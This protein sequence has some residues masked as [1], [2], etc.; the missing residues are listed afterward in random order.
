V[1]GVVGELDR[2]AAGGVHDVEVPR[3]GA[4]GC[5]GDARVVGG[6][7]G[8]DVVGGVGGQLGDAARSDALDVD[9]GGAPVL[10]AGEDDAIALMGDVRIEVGALDAV[11]DLHEVLRPVVGAAAGG[12][13]AHRAVDAQL[14]E[15][16]AGGA[17]VDGGDARACEGGVVGLGGE[18]IKEVLVRGGLL[19]VTRIGEARQRGFVAEVGPVARG[20]GRERQGDASGGQCQRCA[21]GGDVELLERHPAPPCGSLPG[22]RGRPR[23]RLGG[24]TARAGVAPPSLD[25]AE[26]REEE[27]P[28]RP[29]RGACRRSASIGLSDAAVARLERARS[30]PSRRG[31]HSHRTNAGTG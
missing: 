26:A 27:E 25:S 3:A 12:R 4:I 8:H 29:L 30:G 16:G 14:A 24:A 23:N 5:E 1:G 21:N 11:R 10:G 7:G 17:V 2:L 9:V 13:I 15:V 6:D 31:Q 22:R 20:A 18:G 19:A 28:C